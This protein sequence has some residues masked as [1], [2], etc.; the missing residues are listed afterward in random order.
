MTTDLNQRRTL[1]WLVL[2]LGALWLAGCSSQPTSD[3]VAHRWD[4]PRAVN[5]DRAIVGDTP[6]A[7][8]SLVMYELNLRAFSDSADLAGATARLDDLDA[9]GIDVVWLMPIQPV[10]KE[11]AVGALGSPYSIADYT[12]I[13]PEYGTADDLSTFIDQAHQRDMRVILDWVANHTAWDHP[14]TLNEGWH[15]RDAAG[16]IISPPDTQWGDVAELNYDNPEL[17]TAMVEAMRYWLDEYAVDGFRLDYAEGVPLDF[18]SDTITTLEAHAGRELLVLA[19]GADPAL[20]D[21]GADVTFGWDFYGTLKAVYGSEQRSAK[22]VALAHERE[23]GE[24][25]AGKQR[26][27]FTTNHDETAW[28]ATPVALFGGEAGAF[29]AFTLAATYGGVPLVYNGQEIGW[30]RQTSFFDRD[31]IDWS[32]EGPSLIRYRKLLATREDH[33]ALQAGERDDF[34]NDDVAA[35]T[36][37]VAGDTVLVVANTRDR[38]ASVS[39]PASLRGRRAVDTFSDQAVALPATLTLKPHASHVL[40]VE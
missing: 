31:P 9:L 6:S 33:P 30:P 26:L 39:L 16:E 27:R 22:E 13:S 40:A 21:A 34:S 29:G 38:A 18:W 25:P 4:A 3:T 35:F 5:R 36:R 14:W 37:T 24:V 15:V 20:Y 23:Y 2:A 17:R 28:D 1:V 32:Y 7:L 19:E 12:A 10:G 8:E 11:R